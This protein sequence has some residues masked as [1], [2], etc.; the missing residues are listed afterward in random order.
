MS[1][2]WRS[3]RPYIT[4]GPEGKDPAAPS[5][6]RF[7]K[8]GRGVRGETGITG[9]GV[10]PGLDAGRCER[11]LK[12]TS[13]LTGGCLLVSAVVHILGIGC[14]LVFGRAEGRHLDAFLKEEACIVSIVEIGQFEGGPKGLSGAAPG[15]PRPGKAPEAEVRRSDETGPCPHGKR[16]VD[17]RPTQRQAPVPEHASPAGAQ[18]HG[19]ALVAE[20]PQA[21]G[22]GTGAGTQGGP[23]DAEAGLAGTPGDRVGGHGQAASQRAGVKEFAKPSY[24]R[25]SRVAGEEGTAVFDV[26]I[27][28]DALPVRITLVKSSGHGALDEA[29]LEALRKSSY[30]PAMENGIPV[31]SVR[32]VEVRFSL[33]EAVNV[34]GAGGKGK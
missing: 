34:A 26:E 1:E 9:A 12:A 31:P 18:P 13:R 10:F 4:G 11:G 33:G 30:V 2:E 14:L 16:A 15:K 21:Q 7:G 20:T 24:P 28:S 23:G 3:A 29:A 22:E 27:S 25:S 5:V 19:I 32:R 6:D 17:T 8:G